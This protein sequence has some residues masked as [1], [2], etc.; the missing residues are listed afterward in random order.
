M[1]KSVSNR[2][3]TLLSSMYGHIVP[4]KNTVQQKQAVEKI[5][6]EQRLHKAPPFEFI[7]LIL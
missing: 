4:N 5:G 2:I 7:T 1:K 3:E 6:K